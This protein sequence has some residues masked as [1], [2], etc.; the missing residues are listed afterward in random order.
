MQKIEISES[1]EDAIQA[2]LTLIGTIEFQGFIDY[3][4]ILLSSLRGID[5]A[6]AGDPAVVR[7][8]SEFVRAF[9]VAIQTASLC[10]S[11]LWE[12]PIQKQIFE[13]HP[14]GEERIKAIDFA[15]RIR[16]RALKDALTYAQD[17]YS[18]LSFQVMG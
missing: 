12:D 2:R 6:L 17:R 5:V 7:E 8:Y 4:K 1:D 18:K 9:D 15:T 14:E 13:C 3:G 10:A 11:N 16:V